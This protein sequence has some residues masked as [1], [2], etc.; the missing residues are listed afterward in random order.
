M[1]VPHLPVYKSVSPEIDGFR[2][3]RQECVHYKPSLADSTTLQTRTMTDRCNNE[4]KDRDK[5]DGEYSTLGYDQ[6]FTSPSN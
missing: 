6:D 1:H 2:R 4:D 3:V 5:T